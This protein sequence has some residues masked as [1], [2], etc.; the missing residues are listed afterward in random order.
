VATLKFIASSTNVPVPQVLA[1][2]SDRTN[3]VGAEYIIM[4]KVR[5]VPAGQVWDNLRI[6]KKK[7]AVCQLA[8]YSAALFGHR[9]ATGGSLYSSGSEFV[10]GPIVIP[11]FY[12]DVHNGPQL[13]P[14][15][16]ATVQRE[17][18]EFR[19]PFDTI[20]DYLLCQIKAELNFLAL[21]RERAYLDATD[22]IEEGKAFVARGKLVLNKA[23]ELY[24]LFPVFFNVLVKMD[25]DT[26]HITG[27]IDF[28]GT[29][30]APTWTCATIPGWL[31]HSDHEES[32]PSNEP[33]DVRVVLLDAYMGAI[34]EA[35]P[36]GEWEQAHLAGR[37][38]R[39]FAR[40]ADYGVFPWGCRG[41][42]VDRQ[43]EWC[44]AHPGVV[45]DGPI[46]PTLPGLDRLPY[47]G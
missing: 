41:E 28:E 33:N 38:Y 42:Y 11:T 45:Y 1:W 24:A 31:L 6:D 14:L 7:V 9:F 39:Y 32:I 2:N 26:G 19:G 16:S 36:T 15:E 29:R 21:H 40:S 27:L 44:T 35:D 37:P 3:T 47:S 10:V 34:R 46:D 17:Q 8:R 20:T 23:L 43:L 13:P 4:E 5:G 12:R 30:I 18:D 25:I 22:D